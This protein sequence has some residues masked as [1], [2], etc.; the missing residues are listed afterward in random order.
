[1][2]YYVHGLLPKEWVT[3]D[4]S[5]WARQIPPPPKKIQM[6]LSCLLPYFFLTTCPV[7]VIKYLYTR[8]LICEDC[9]LQENETTTLRTMSCGSPLSCYQGTSTGKD[10]RKDLAFPINLGFSFQ[11]GARLSTLCVSLGQDRRH[12]YVNPSPTPARSRRKLSCRGWAWNRQQATWPH[13]SKRRKGEEKK[14]LNL[15]LQNFKP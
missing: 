9:Y 10:R 12:L 1:M 3:H 6:C 15:A 4:P 11:Q 14:T 13:H 7:L 8:S 2:N 5:E